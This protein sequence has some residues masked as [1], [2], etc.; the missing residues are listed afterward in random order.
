MEGRSLRSGNC[1]RCTKHWRASKVWGAFAVDVIPLIGT[2]TRTDNIMIRVSS[3]VETWAVPSHGPIATAVEVLPSVRYVPDSGPTAD[4]PS[5]RPSAVVSSRSTA[6]G[7][8]RTR[9]IHLC[10]EP[11]LILFFSFLRPIR[12]FLP[13]PSYLFGAF[14]LQRYIC[15][16]ATYEHVAL[17]K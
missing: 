15:K 3:R 1:S 7:T 16:V 9:A 4:T 17:R 11:F 12:G 13:F 14:F 10:Y 6:K 2:T 5:Q 8:T